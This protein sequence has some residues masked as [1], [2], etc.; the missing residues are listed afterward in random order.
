VLVVA[1]ALL[2]S[3]CKL[4]VDTTVAFTGS[5]TVDVTVSAGL[6]AALA[7]RLDAL[8]VDPF[9]ALSRV[10]QFGWQLNRIEDADGMLRLGLTRDSI[11]FDALGD[12]LAGLSAGISDTDVGL[13]YD[14]EI[15]TDEVQ[16]TLVGT[17]LFTPP[18]TSGIWLDGRPLGLSAARIAEQVAQDVSVFFTV[19][20]D[21]RIVSHNADEVSDTTARWRLG[22]NETVAI[23]IVVEPA[24]EPTG[25]LA[26]IVLSLVLLA[27]GVLLWWRRR[28]QPGETVPTGQM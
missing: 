8:N 5:E 10:R 12:T 9:A 22:V 19:S 7:Q 25:L 17:A 14:L 28:N 21:G 26:V 13:V 6:D 23:N 1:V 4:S 24:K 2:A 3:G 27:G 18:T 16:H 15:V 11:A 20:V